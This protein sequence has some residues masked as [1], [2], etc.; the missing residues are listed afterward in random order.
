MVGGGGREHALAWKLLRDDP[1][2]ELISAPGNPGLA[3]LGR[4]A[5]LSAT[6][7]A[8]LTGIARRERP[9]LTIV[10]PEAPRGSS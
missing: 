10:G 8:S 1:S 7:I 2:L 5:A 9:D 3:E 4:T 6:D